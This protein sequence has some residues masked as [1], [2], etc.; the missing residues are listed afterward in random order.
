MP[1]SYKVSVI[2]TINKDKYEVIAVKAFHTLQDPEIIN[3]I[4][5]KRLKLN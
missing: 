5:N 1:N 4:I 2:Y 3:E